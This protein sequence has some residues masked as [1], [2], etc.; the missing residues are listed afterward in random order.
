[1]PEVRQIME[2][3]FGPNGKLRAW[4]VPIDNTNVLLAV[5]TEEQLV[6]RLKVVDKIQKIDWTPVETNAANSMLP[7]EADWRVFLDGHRYYAWKAREMAAVVGVPMFGGSL[8]QAFPM[9]PC[10]GIAGGF[11]DSELWVEVATPAL[12]VKAIDMY[13]LR[14]RTRSGLQLRARVVGPAVPA[15]KPAPAPAPAQK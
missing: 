13:F 12:T 11:R 9:S 14:N 2:K 7:A 6:E 5:G 3:M 8:V 1:M 15:Q 4:I 10:I